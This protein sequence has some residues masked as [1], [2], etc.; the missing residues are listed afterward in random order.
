MRET[1][2]VATSA[3]AARRRRCRLR[4]SRRCRFSRSAVALHAEARA[5]PANG[6][7]RPHQDTRGSRRDRMPAAPDVQSSP[8]L[9]A[10]CAARTTL[11]DAT[12]FRSLRPSRL[13]EAV[14][15][16]GWQ[17]TTKPWRLWPAPQ[18]RLPSA[19]SSLAVLQLAGVAC[20]P[21][22]SRSGALADPRFQLHKPCKGTC[23][24]P[25]RFGGVVPR[26]IRHP[27]EL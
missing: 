4:V 5:R 19:I 7:R 26:A 15:R 18:N 3:G 21:P 25:V 17:P 27:L 20:V 10:V 24:S 13:M 1:P 2:D 23:S 9:G 16:R 8:L 14:L 6:S 12:R 22:A 11:S